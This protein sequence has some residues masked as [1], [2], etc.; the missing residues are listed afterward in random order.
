MTAPT[1]AASTATATNRSWAF[2]GPVEVLLLLVAVVWGGSYSAAKIA[3]EQVPVLQ[4]LLLRFGLTFLLLLPALRGLAVAAWPSAL[5]GASLLGANLLAIFVC[6]TFGVSLTTASNA[7]FLI[8]LCVAFTPLCEWWLLKV[9]P[10]AGVLTASALSLLGAGL[11]AF[12]HGVSVSALAWGD[13]L[14]VVAAFLRGVMVCL[15]RRQGLRHGLPA[16]TVTAVQMG[17]MTLGS[18]LLMIAVQGPVWTPL[19]SSASFWGAMA[20]LVLLCTLLAFFVQNY[21]ASRTSPSRV[22][23][24]MGSEP[25]WGALIAVVW[26]GDRLTLQGW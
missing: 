26:L 1:L 13:A 19:P 22:A 14:M 12:Q 18:G 11:L 25:L 21:A 24:L 6:E 4:F 2:L 3:T 15:T 20:F 8:S 23:L 16:L 5:V 17:V 10:T 9:R 7:A